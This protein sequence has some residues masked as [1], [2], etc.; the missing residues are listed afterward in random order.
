MGLGSVLLPNRKKL[1]VL[2]LKKT[3][4]VKVLFSLKSD[5]LFKVLIACILIV[6]CVME[7][8]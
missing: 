4:I 3:V 7:H 5:R 1:L 8:T 2:Q 6:F